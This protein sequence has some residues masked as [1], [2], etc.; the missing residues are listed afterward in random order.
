MGG[1]MSCRIRLIGRYSEV[2][3]DGC[4]PV[5]E[6]TIVHAARLHLATSHAITRFT[7][8][9]PSYRLSG[10]VQDSQTRT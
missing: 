1:S 10:D 7:L 4:V 2:V 9:C 6:Q 5:I 8:P 3:H